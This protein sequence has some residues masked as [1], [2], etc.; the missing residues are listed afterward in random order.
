MDTRKQSITNRLT[1][2]IVLMTLLV[3][4]I[5]NLLFVFIM[6][7]ALVDKTKEDFIKHGQLVA[8]TLESALSEPNTRLG[9]G[10]RMNIE[11]RYNNL[12][13]GL[14]SSSLYL[15]DSNF[16]LLSSN[17]PLND[18]E[19]LFSHSDYQRINLSLLSYQEQQLQTIN[20]DGNSLYLVIESSP[21]TLHNLIGDASIILLLSTLFAL[22]IAFV[23]TRH[24]SQRITAPIKEL[25]LLTQEYAGGD[26][27]HRIKHHQDDEIG[28]LS[29]SINQFANELQLA[30]KQ[31]EKELEVQ[32]E[33]IATISH[34]LKT[35]ISVIQLSIEQ[36]AKQSNHALIQNLQSESNHLNTLIND[37]LVLT[38]LQ[39]PEFR[40]DVSEVSIHDILTDVVR[41]F[42]LKAQ[43]RNI[44]IQLMVH[45]DLTI[46]GD[47]DRLR[48][49]FSNVLD[50]A[51]KHSY[52]NS[53]ILIKQ[54]QE[55]SI[56]IEDFGH[57]IHPDNLTQIFKRYFRESSDISGSGLGL[58]I[59]KEIADRH[60]IELSVESQMN[61]GTS[62]TFN[63]TKKE[64]LSSF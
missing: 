48:Q 1:K 28:L 6:G 59:T 13:K 20:I 15:Y 64:T 27:S 31:K 25:T 23:Y 63:F 45:S 33:F 41:S 50:N 24:I 7:N 37:L 10:N 49:M 54:P 55:N 57:G 35:P 11:R 18:P 32:R 14:S 5:I 42:R 61:K 26:Y 52:E 34:E 29:Q 4:L 39:Q 2:Q 58:A 56:V 43:E 60:L 8:Q 40:L 36:L 44:S 21:R 12:L 17:P 47:Y 51:L 22:G 53:Q 9:H 16:T 19:N 3:M 38:K 62:F 30:Q 46:L